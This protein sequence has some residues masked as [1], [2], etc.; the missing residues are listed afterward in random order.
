M[1]T[2]FNSKMYLYPSKN[3]WYFV[4]MA[5]ED[6][7]EHTQIKIEYK[8]KPLVRPTNYIFDQVIDI[9]KNIA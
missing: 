9:K 4:F 1:D 8:P 7:E 6:I 3:R 5:S 2:D